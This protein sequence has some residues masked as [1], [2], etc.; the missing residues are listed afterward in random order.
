MSVSLLTF[1]RQKNNPSPHL[2]S[3]GASVLFDEIS[4]KVWNWGA[5]GKTRPEVEDLSMILLKLAGLL[6]LA[7]I[8]FCV[9][10][11]WVWPERA[12]KW[13]PLKRPLEGPPNNSK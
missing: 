6:L 1:H 12:P 11:W 4:E 2:A 13:Y 9:F 10:Y 7:I 3:R 8:L 5:S